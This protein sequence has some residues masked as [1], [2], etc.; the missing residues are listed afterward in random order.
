MN[1]GDFLLPRKVTFK[2]TFSSVPH[3]V[4]KPHRYFKSKYE[5]QVEKGKQAGKHDLEQDFEKQSHK[6]NPQLNTKGMM[7]GHSVGEE[8]T[9][10]GRCR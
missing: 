1:A 5:R 7:K 8:S 2:V 4:W 9:S 10:T 3:C 6:K